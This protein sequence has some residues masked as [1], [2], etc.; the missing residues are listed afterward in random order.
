MGNLQN[1]RKGKGILYKTLK[2]QEMAKSGKCHFHSSYWALANVSSEPCLVLVP[3][4]SPSLTQCLLPWF[5]LGGGC[6]SSQCSVYEEVEESFLTLIYFGCLY[7]KYAV[8]WWDSSWICKTGPVSF[9][10]RCVSLRLF[11]CLSWFPRG[12]SKCALSTW[13][14]STELK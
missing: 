14:W 9:V 12:I 11:L 1:I 2:T 10:M 8:G 4:T 13:F 7:S 5:S 6:G 3:L